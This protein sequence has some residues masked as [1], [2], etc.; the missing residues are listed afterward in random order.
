[1]ETGD[2]QANIKAQE[3]VD[4]LARFSIRERG[5]FTTWNRIANLFLEKFGYLST[6]IQ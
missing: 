2:R 4:H 3:A 1:L 6:I 5:D